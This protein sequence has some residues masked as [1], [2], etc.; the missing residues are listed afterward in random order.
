MKFTELK[1]DEQLQEAISYMG[2]ENATPI[3]AKA[4][5]LVLENK[6]LIACAQTGTGKTGAFL[7]PVLNK[8]VGKEDTNIDTLIIVPTRELAI[9]IEQQI[10]GLGYFVSAGSIAIYGG[11]GGKEWQIQKEALTNGVDIVVSTPGK[12]I[13]HLKMGYVNFKHVKHLILDEADRMLDMGFIDDLKSIISYLPAQRQTL[14]FSATMPPNIKQLAK[15]IMNDPA[16]IAL[17]ISK[18]AA[19]VAQKMYMAH[20]NQ[21]IKLLAHILS[22][23][24]NYDSIIVFTSTKSKVSEIVR[25]LGRAGLKATGISSNL[26]QERREEVLRGFRAKRIRILVATDVM[27][28]GIDIKEINMVVNYDVPHDAEDYVHRVGRTARANTKGEA[29]T[30][31]NEKDMHK[32]WKIEKLIETKIEKLHPPE[33]MGPGPEWK[34]GRAGGGGNKRKFNKNKNNKFRGKNRGPRKPNSG[35][36][37]KPN[38]SSTKP[39]N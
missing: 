29:F 19:G 31:I 20:D 28:R 8:L 4:I 34:E 15:R 36:G 2:F 39:S 1:L 27:S 21:K 6:D 3:Q 22:E 33:K 14:M 10:Q 16:E 37:Q 11:G 26:E 18:P 13:S 32:V 35:G 7:L 24:K 9:Q 12:L 17:S 25:S 30:L 5:P 23:R 38:T